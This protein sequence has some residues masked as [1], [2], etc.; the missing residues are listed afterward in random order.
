[1]IKAYI[2]TTLQPGKSDSAVD[3][4]RKI[5]NVDSISIVAGEYDVILR[6]QVKSLEN[7]MKLTNKLQMIDGIKRTTTQVIEKEI[8]L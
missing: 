4:M 6:V 2:L 5:K 3:E 1:M 7:L 8:T